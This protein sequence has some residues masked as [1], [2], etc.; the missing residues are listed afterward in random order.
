[1]TEVWQGPT[2]RVR[3]NEDI[4]LVYFCLIFIMNDFTGYTE[5]SHMSNFTFETQR[6]TFH[7][8]GEFI[9]GDF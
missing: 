8:Y 3:F 2:P 1:M 9:L 6:K 4:C 7:S 5:A